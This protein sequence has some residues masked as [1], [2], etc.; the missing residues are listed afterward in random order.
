MDDDFENCLSSDTFRFIRLKA[1]QLTGKYGF[2]RDDIDD[3]QQSLVLDYLQ[4]VR[5]FDADRGDSDHFARHIV[6]HGVA[7]LIESQRAACR[8]YGNRLCSVST[9]CGRPESP[10]LADSISEE[11]RILKRSPQKLE[12]DLVLRVDVAKAV[13][14]L[15]DDLR[16]VCLF[17]MALDHV[18]QVATAAGVS[19]AT[20]YRRIRAIRARFIQSQLCKTRYEGPA[21]RGAVRG[22]RK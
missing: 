15:P 20:L 7:R 2:L 12:R 5:R 13:G 9:A 21:T 22:G 10:D 4:R 18:G 19:R 1:N 8:G 14:A 11:D 3:I 16:R 17:L 6:K